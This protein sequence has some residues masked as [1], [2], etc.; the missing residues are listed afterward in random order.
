M[1]QVILVA[2]RFVDRPRQMGMHGAEGPDAENAAARTLQ[3]SFKGHMSRR[4]VDAR[5]WLWC[6]SA[7]EPQTLGEEG[8]SRDNSAAGVGRK[9]EPKTARLRG[10]LRSLLS[11]EC[12]RLFL[13]C[14]SRAVARGGEEWEEEEEGRQI[15]MEGFERACEEL[16]PVFRRLPEEQVHVLFRASCAA[17]ERVA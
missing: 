4:V 2:K 14:S 3:S 10:R 16:L 7:K 8:A 9:R 5:L 13:A 6:F 12:A 15:G 11:R 17:A 1:C